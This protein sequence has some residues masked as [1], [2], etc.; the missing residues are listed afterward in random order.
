MALDAN[1]FKSDFTEVV[2]KSNEEF[3][4]HFV[5]IF[6]RKRGPSIT[7]SIRDFGEVKK[8]DLANG[9]W[10]NPHDNRF[11]AVI[12][13]GDRAN[14]E[15][16]HGITFSGMVVTLAELTEILG[17]YV[18]GTRQE[19]KSAAFIFTMNDSNAW[20]GA[21]EFNVRKRNFEKA[22]DGK[23]FELKEGGPMEEVSP[24]DLSFNVFTV[25]FVDPPGRTELFEEEEAAKSERKK[26]E[27]MTAEEIAEAKRQEK[28]E[29][30]KRL[31]K[32]GTDQA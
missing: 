17:D 22:E 4:R 8:W 5:T 23:L 12:L 3:L 21:F 10:C 19:D 26:Y 1:V 7:R 25:H 27:G 16:V 29:R 24:A 30:V 11:N 28:L 9:I 13:L 32:L 2:G 14:K 15:L 6:R 18:V 31:T 20:I